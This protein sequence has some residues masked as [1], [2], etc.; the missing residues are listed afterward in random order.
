MVVFVLAGLTICLR[1]FEI[2]SVTELTLDT[3]GLMPIGFLWIF[4]RNYNWDVL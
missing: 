3:I 4:F 1:R 2:L